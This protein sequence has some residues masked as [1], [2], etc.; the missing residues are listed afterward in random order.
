MTFDPARARHIAK[1]EL[2]NKDAQH[3]LVAAADLVEAL[4]DSFPPPSADSTAAL[5]MWAS[6]A[7][8]FLKRGRAQPT[9]RARW[10]E[11]ILHTP[12]EHDKPSGACSEPRD[13]EGDHVF[14]N[15]NRQPNK[16]K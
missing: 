5:A 16:P 14:P 10:R 8:A 1:L 7:V 11:G 12:G 2:A 9:C 3:Q 6:D 13:H 15:N 4:I